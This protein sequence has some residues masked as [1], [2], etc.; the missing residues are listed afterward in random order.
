[1]KKINLFLSFMLVAFLVNT[2][3]TQIKTPAASPSATIMQT[4]GLVDV[5]VNYSRPSVKGRTIFAADGLVPLGQVWRF[6]ANQAT[7]LTT[8]GDIM[9]NDKTLSAGSYA[10]LALPGKSN[11][12]VHFFNYEKS[13]W[14]SYKEKTP[15][16]KVMVKPMS[17]P[18]SVESL[19]FMF[20]NLKDDG[21]DMMM[22]WDKTAISI[23]IKVATDEA[24]MKNIETVLAGPSKGDYY[25]A[26]SYYF[27]SGKDL[28]KAYEM[29]TKATDGPDQK[30]WQMR[31]RS[32]IEAALGKYKN[33]IASA[34]TSME[35][36]EKAGNMEYVKF[37]KT[38][39]AEWKKK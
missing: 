8:K 5:E 13:S 24:V 28:N 9:V 20:S 36:A 7:K 12:E 35:L 32:Q 33:A 37:N 11:W 39:I 27:S 29:V 31:R 18:K 3:N 22:M 2:G 23:P 38:A 4:I 34:T 10:M 30:Y 19:T 15:I 16:A 17:L 26:A 21:A 6:G 1:M 25:N 14:S